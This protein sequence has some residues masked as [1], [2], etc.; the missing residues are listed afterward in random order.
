MGLS[1]GVVG[2][3]LAVGVYAQQA[4]QCS[5]RECCDVKCAQNL[6]GDSDVKFYE[7][8]GRDQDIVKGDSGASDLAVNRLVSDNPFLA[9]S[10]N[11]HATQLCD[12]FC[13]RDCDVES[14]PSH[15]SSNTFYM[16]HSEMVE[17]YLLKAKDGLGVCTVCISPLPNAT[18][19]D[20]CKGDQRKA[21]HEIST[22]ISL[23]NSPY[24]PRGAMHLTFRTGHNDAQASP[25]KA[26]VRLSS[27]DT[28]HQVVRVDL[29]KEYEYLVT[30][31]CD[32]K[33]HAEDLCD[34]RDRSVVY[35]KNRGLHTGH[36]GNGR[37]FP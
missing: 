36:Q 21:Y 14:A 37:P 5:T 10:C 23:S 6:L 9:R 19:S 16:K 13:N 31:C 29:H 26:G 24:L 15:E 8:D 1:T 30:S 28:D 34:D 3:F 12:A 18:D 35:G 33:I 11:C 27:L 2:L 32:L 20:T 22:C 25:S 7:I 4:P 17:H